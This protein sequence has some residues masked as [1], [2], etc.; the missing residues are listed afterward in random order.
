MKPA[1]TTLSSWPLSLPPH[2]FYT[3]KKNGVT[4]VFCNSCQSAPQC[5]SRTQSTESSRSLPIIN[6]KI[7]V[8]WQQIFHSGTHFIL[9]SFLVKIKCQRNVIIYSKDFQSSPFQL[10][11]SILPSIQITVNKHLLHEAQSSSCRTHRHGLASCR[12]RQ[13]SPEIMLEV[14][15]ALRQR[16][17]EYGWV[18]L[19]PA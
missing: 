19:S 3:G 5:A 17:V 16:C 2:P 9:Q 8:S 11:H 15:W 6:T 7:T 1:Q 13:M 4:H 10:K 14:C 18:L 12:K